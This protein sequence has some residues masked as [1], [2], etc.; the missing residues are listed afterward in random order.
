M[1]RQSFLKGAFIL[2]IAGFITKILGFINR[3]VMARILGEEG[4]GLYMM[5]VPTFI[6]AITLTQIGLPVAIAKFVAEAEAV[7]DKQKIKKILTVSLAVTSFISIILTIGIM[8]LTPILAKTLLTDERTYYPLMAILPVVPVIAVSSVLR[9][10]FQGKQNM[11]PSAYAQVIEQ[12]VRITIIAVCIRIF[13]PYGVEYA[14][15]GAMLSAVLGEVASL[16]FLLTLFQREKHL[17]IRSRFFT[18]V[19]ESKGTFYSLMDIALPTTGSRLIGSVSYFFEPIVVMQSLAIAGVA[20]SVATQ[21][22][23]I[24]NGYAFPLLSLPAFI[25]YALSTA[26]VPSISEAM[27]KRQHKLVEHRLQQALRI[28][29]ITGGWSV[30]ILYVF[31]S[32]VLTLMYGSDSATAFIQLLAPCFLFH[33]FQS[34]LTSVLQALNLARAAMMNTFIGAIVKLIVIFVLAS[35]PEFQMMGVALAIAANIVTVTFLHYATVLKKITFTIYAKDYIFGGLAIGIAGAF[36]FYL[37][38][39]IIFSHSLGIQTLW[40]ITLTTIVYVVLLFIFKLIR[41]EELSRLPIIRK[42]SFLK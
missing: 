17:S 18:T 16:L 12:V 29:L 8:L 15:A 11:K 1:T 22:Y 14:A 42:L 4:V 24:L 7:N 35:K 37:H 39:Y 34:P 23:G 33:Y 38:K 13:L 26:L 41:K 32:P 2:M 25:T 30:V 19:K 27:A 5:A 36:G 3:I 28:S 21:Q 40:E 9:G 10:Y 20:A 6:L 31:A